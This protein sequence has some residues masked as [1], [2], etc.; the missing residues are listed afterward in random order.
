MFGLKFLRNSGRDVIPLYF[1]HQ[2]PFGIKS[3]AFLEGLDIGVLCGTLDEQPTKGESL[4]AFWRNQRYKFFD[5]F[6]DRPVVTCHHLSDQIETMVMGFAHGKIRKIPA[7]RG[8]YIRPFLNVTKD[9]IL[10][11]C[12]RH[13]V[14]FVDDP[15]NN[16]TRFARNRIRA[17]VI[18]ELL[19]VNPGLFKSLGKLKETQH[20]D[21][22]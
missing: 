17:N 11:Y 5:Q 15:S 2:T 7:I 19:K 6:A 9:E 13:E 18:P 21:N 12:E 16:D 14:K 22:L 10:S 4:E 20:G 3:Q 8:N 1:N